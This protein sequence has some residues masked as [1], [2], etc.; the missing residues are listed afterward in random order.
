MLFGRRRSI[1]VN[2]LFDYKQRYVNGFV[3]CAFI[4]SRHKKKFKK[5]LSS[6][7]YKLVGL[8]RVPCGWPW[9]I[10]K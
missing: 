8:F 6:V 7:A 3:N 5:M 9:Y 1:S 10:K 4:V 2:R